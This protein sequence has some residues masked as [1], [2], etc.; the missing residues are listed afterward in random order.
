[1]TNCTRCG[2]QIPEGTYAGNVCPECRQV[3]FAAPAGTGPV[4]QAQ[5]PVLAQRRS[6][7][8]R[9]PVTTAILAANV[10]V[11]LVT[12][13][14]GK[15]VARSFGPVVEWGANYGPL[16]LTGQFWRV[17][18]SNY[19]HDGIIHVA[20][21]MWSLWQVG[22][23]A[24]RIFG[25]AAYF[26]TYTLCGIAAS[27][28]SLYWNPLRPSVGASG[29]LFGILGTLIAVLA[30]GKLPFPPQA[31]KGLLQ[32]LLVVSFINL[33]YG[34]QAARIDNSAHVGGFLAGLALGALLAPLI[35]DPPEQRQGRA[36][37]IF[38]GAAAFLVAFGMFVKQ[39]RGPIVEKYLRSAPG[40][41][42]PSGPNP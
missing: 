28:A 32:N 15:S 25:G 20:V 39:S 31:R 9:P 12:V 37:L 10:L 3:A 4:L 6:A 34:A 42:Q 29:A 18:T 2:R 13:A 24:E 1:M 7:P 14:T 27:L 11:F 26:A 38:V 33:V 21:N 35:N 36:R 5:P 16:T 19:I 23:L 8:Y 40:M 30:L 17:L 41:E 22:R